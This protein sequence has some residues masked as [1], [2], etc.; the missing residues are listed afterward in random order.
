M[1]RGLAQPDCNGFVRS[2]QKRR[3]HVVSLLFLKPVKIFLPLPLFHLIGE[4]ARGG[5]M[6][7]ALEASDV[8]E[9]E[10]D[11][12]L[13]IASRDFERIADAR[14]NVNTTLYPT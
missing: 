2:S 12:D 5:K 13:L 6:A 7:E 4:N 3:R 14:T 10:G 11:S 9:L 8:V 1:R